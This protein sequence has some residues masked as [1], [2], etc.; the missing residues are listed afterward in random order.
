MG[1]LPF[2]ESLI[3]G[4]EWAA[5]GMVTYMTPEL[6]RV[7]PATYGEVKDIKT[8]NQLSFLKSG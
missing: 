3:Y 7:D 5:T 2:N 8:L 6:I 4:T 1:G